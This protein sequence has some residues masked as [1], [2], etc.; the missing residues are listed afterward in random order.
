[1]KRSLRLLAVLLALTLAAGATAALATEVSTVLPSFDDLYVELP[2]LSVVLCREPD[3]VLT[4]A[5]GSVT[6]AFTGVTGEDFD[7]F[8]VHLT[9]RGCTMASYTLKAGIFRAELTCGS[10]TFTFQY[11]HGTASARLIYPAGSLVEAYEPV[12]DAAEAAADT[13]ETDLAGDPESARGPVGTVVIVD[14]SLEGSAAE[15]DKGHV[16][17]PESVIFGRYEQDNNP[18]N[19]PEPIEWLVL[20]YDEFSNRVL[21]LSRYGLDAKPYNTG[22]TSVVWKSCS[23]RKWLNEE[24]LN[25]AFTVEEQAVVLLTDVDN[26]RNQSALFWASDSGLNTQDKVFLLSCAE[27]AQYLGAS[28]GDIHNFSPRVSPTAYARAQGAFAG[29][30]MTSEGSAAGWWWLRSPGYHQNEAARVS[31]DG[32]LG[33]VEVNNS[34]G[35]VRPALWVS[36][37][38]P[39]SYNLYAFNR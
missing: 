38:A 2:S 24:F 32:S 26:S 37:D 33:T 25:A 7:R 4:G 14:E 23:L 20:D 13:V 5:D 8:N 35:S 10:E 12:Q 22:K 3:E 21:L 19:G 39:A 34:R 27:V 1:M 30:T 36:L 28:W 15:P 31:R 29:N 9:E 6:H 17:E 16:E 11:D 18:D